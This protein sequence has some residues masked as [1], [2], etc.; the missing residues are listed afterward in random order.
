[1]RKVTQKFNMSL[2]ARS[3]IMWDIP[4][5]KK[6]TPHLISD[7]NDDSF[8]MVSIKFLVSRWYIIEFQ[9]VHIPVKMR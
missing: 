8:Q 7:K 4:M 3:V 6:K 9:R 5:F 1:M 2:L